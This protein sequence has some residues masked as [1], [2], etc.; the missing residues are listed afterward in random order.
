MFYPFVD[1]NTAVIKN[2]KSF[3]KIVC[4]VAVENMILYYRFHASLTNL[5][6]WIENRN[7][8]HLLTHLVSYQKVAFICVN[9]RLFLGN[10]FLCSLG[11]VHLDKHGFP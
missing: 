10:Q 5:V 6:Y 3:I 2:R 9:F 8:T 1:L 11:I 4:P 7:G